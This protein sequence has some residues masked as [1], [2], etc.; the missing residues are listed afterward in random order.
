[1]TAHYLPGDDRDER[2]A[3]LYGVPETD[4][5]PDP[6]DYLGLA[7]GPTDAVYSA[8]QEA[9]EGVRW[10]DALCHCGRNELRHVWD[11]QCREC[12][13]DALA[14]EAHERGLAG[15]WE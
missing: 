6:S 2:R 8:T 12:D 13:D 14:E 9:A 11:H 3:A 15:E 10:G 1:M 4:D 5:R 7:D